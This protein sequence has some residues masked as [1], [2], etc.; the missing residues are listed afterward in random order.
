M[1]RYAAKKDINHTAIARILTDAGAQVFDTSRLPGA[2]DLIA[3]YRG[4]L[5]WLEIKQPHCRDDLTEMERA[6]IAR[7]RLVNAPVHIV[8]SADEAL[9]AIGAV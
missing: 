7:L 8:C 2:L 6:T 3:A 9:K 5:I 1:P 4:R